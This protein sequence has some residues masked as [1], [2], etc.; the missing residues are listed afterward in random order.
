MNNQ[1]VPKIPDGFADVFLFNPSDTWRKTIEKKYKVKTDVVYSDNY[2][3]VWKL[4]KFSKLRRRNIPPN[5]LSA[6]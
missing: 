2:Y 1:K 3:S 6:S 5:K 4:T